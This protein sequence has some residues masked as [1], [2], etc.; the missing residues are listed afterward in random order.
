M[1][2]RI[3]QILRNLHTVH[4][5]R[6]DAW[7]KRSDLVHWENLVE[8]ELGGG[9]GMGNTCKPMAVS[10]HC[11]TKSTTK[12]KKRKNL[13]NSRL[14]RKHMNWNDWQNSKKN[15]SALHQL[16]QVD[17]DLRLY[18]YTR[19]ACLMMLLMRRNLLFYW[20]LFYSQ[21]LL[22]YHF[23]NTIGCYKPYYKLL[24]YFLLILFAF[25]AILLDSIL[26]LSRELS[27]LGFM[28]QLFPF[29]IWAYN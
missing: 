9:I 13:P 5:P 28:F 27:K 10:F 4:Q 24:P 15:I 3:C 25:V 2:L 22:Q 17:L 14:I 16:R 12:K 19:E 20:Q 23:E 1:I 29:L 26:S 6:L 21:N 11:M 8:R 7:D 18:R